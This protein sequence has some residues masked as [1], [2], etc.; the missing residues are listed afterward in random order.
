[1][2]GSGF[3]YNDLKLDNFLFDL[4]VDSKQLNNSEENFFE[5]HKINII[6]FGYATPYLNSETNEHF[7]KKRLDT[8]RG[9]ME[10]SSLNQMKFYSTSRRDDLISLFYLMV[11]LLKRGIIPGFGKRQNETSTQQD[12]EDIF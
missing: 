4:G 8:F 7:E 2:H 6:D 10:F 5:K 9:N 3:V 1:M 12:F 11:Y